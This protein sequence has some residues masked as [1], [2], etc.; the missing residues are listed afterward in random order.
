V[1]SAAAVV[2]GFVAHDPDVRIGGLVLNCVGS[3]WHRAMLDE[4]LRP[5]G[6]PVLGALPREA[7]IVLPERHLGLVQVGEHDAFGA[8]LARFGLPG[9]TGAI[10]RLRRAL[11]TLVF[12]HDALHAPPAR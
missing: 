7:T 10:D 4:A 3:A 9:E 12:R 2:R 11:D 6:L 5:L 1:Q 8:H